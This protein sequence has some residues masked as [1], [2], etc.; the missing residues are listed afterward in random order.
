MRGDS[1]PQKIVPN[2]DYGCVFSERTKQRVT[3]PSDKAA[4]TVRAG[5][6]GEHKCGGIKIH[7]PEAE[8]SSGNDTHPRFRKITLD[9][10]DP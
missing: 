6:I 8:D 7:E 1:H 2:A 5:T 4:N 3:G 10:V 9:N